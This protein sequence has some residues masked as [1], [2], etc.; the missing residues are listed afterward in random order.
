MVIEKII[1]DIIELAHLHS[2][3]VVGVEGN[4][5]GKISEDLMMI[6]ASGKKLENLTHEDLVRC[7]LDGNSCEVDR[8]PS[9]ESPFHGWIIQNLG[10][11]FVAHT[12]PKNSMVLL[13]GSRSEEFAY[14]RFFPDQVVFNGVESCLVPYVHPGEELFFE[15]QSSVRNF[16]KLHKQPPKIILLQNHGIITWGKTVGECLIKTQICEKSAYILSRCSNPNPLS[17]EQIAKIE[18]DLKENYR[19]SQI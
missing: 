10:A 16:Q 15:I 3:W 9:M 12:H 19:K 14:E 1:S 4:V 8:I 6:K 17:D 18:Y 13:C 11:N 2:D 7:Y 5:S